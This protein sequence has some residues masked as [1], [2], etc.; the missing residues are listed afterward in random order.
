MKSGIVVSA[1]DAGTPFD[2]SQQAVSK[3]LACLERAGL[4]NK[5]REGRQ[6]F[7]RLNPAPL[8]EIVTWV[9]SCQRFWEESFERLDVVIED[10]KSKKRKKV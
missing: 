3:H 4:I 2:M 8:D 7:C 5:S 9:D 1:S 6:H 10:I